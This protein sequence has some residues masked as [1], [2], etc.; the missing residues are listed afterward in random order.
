MALLTT[1]LTLSLNTHSIPN[2]DV[3]VIGGGPSGLAVS[4]ALEGLEPYYEGELLFNDKIKELSQKTLP[5]IERKR[6]ENPV[7]L[8]FAYLNDQGLL[9]FKKGLKNRVK[10]LVLTEGDIG[11]CWNDMEGK[12]LCL[13]PAKW[14]ALP[15]FP[16][17][18]FEGRKTEEEELP[19]MGE[20]SEYY[21]AYAQKMALTENI[22][23][24]TKV[25]AIER[26]NEI[27]RVHATCQGIATTYEA[28]AIVIANGNYS[29]PKRLGVEGEELSFVTHRL[30]ADVKQGTTVLV[31][32]SGLTAADCVIKALDAGCTV[33]HLYRMKVKKGVDRFDGR[34]KQ[35][36]HYAHLWQLMSQMKSD[37]RYFP[38]VGS[39]LT[40]I[41]E[42]GL[43]LI[44]SEEVKVDQVMVLI[45]S[46]SDTSFF[47]QIDPSQIEEK[48]DKYSYELFDNLFVVGPLTGDNFIKFNTPGCFA[49]ASAL[50]KK[51][52]DKAVVE[53]AG[54]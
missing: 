38:H 1:F 3:I 45:G 42:G 31:V 14:M 16:W 50:R 15:G 6:S 30:P 39:D 9:T 11:G 4:A 19:T 40:K 27:W 41:S 13:S 20:V 23:T 21:K 43:C 52:I 24:H 2:T 25:T 34:D 17:K 51:E 18:D 26:I 48:V 46:K 33:H 35:Y 44:D 53:T 7:S 54:K 12:M 37:K 29:I 47:P 36:P 28:K 5:K 8:T 32:G 22:H 49:A 10:H